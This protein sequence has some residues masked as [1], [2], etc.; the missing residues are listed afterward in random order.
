[1]QVISKP[2][3]GGKTY[4]LIMA[5]EVTGY[6]IVTFTEAA[7]K[8]VKSMAKDIGCNIP[9]PVTAGQLHNEHVR[10]IRSY[11]NVLLDDMEYVIQDALNKYLHTNVIC[12]MTSIGSSS[13][14]RE[15]QENKEEI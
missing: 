8:H 13:C 9:E 7:R 15:Q 3:Q 12:S 5:S 1:M 2:R 10:G 14:K 6:P 11:E 4:Q